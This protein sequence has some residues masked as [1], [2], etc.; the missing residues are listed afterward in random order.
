MTESLPMPPGQVGMGGAL[1]DEES[2]FAAVAAASR[3]LQEE[4]ESLQKEL[5][6]LGKAQQ[7]VRA[8]AEEWETGQKD[9]DDAHNMITMRKEDLAQLQVRFVCPVK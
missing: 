1:S 7:E 9:L 5:A 8:D 4:S 3:A 6:A 2:L